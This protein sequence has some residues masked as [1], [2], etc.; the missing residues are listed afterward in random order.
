M[1]S[2]NGFLGLPKEI[3]VQILEYVMPPLNKNGC[4]LRIVN[5]E[6]QDLVDVELE[7]RWSLVVRYIAQGQEGKQGLVDKLAILVLDPSILAQPS[8]S[9]FLAISHGLAKSGI[10]IPKGELPITP[11]HFENLLEKGPVDNRND[12]KGRIYRIYAVVASA[13]DRMIDNLAM[14][15]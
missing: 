5:R 2:V 7:R 4:A 10:A 3:Q 12:L 14:G 13:L 1:S 9:R 15:L 8:L 11:Y 6:C